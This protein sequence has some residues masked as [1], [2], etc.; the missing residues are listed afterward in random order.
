MNPPPTSTQPSDTQPSGAERRQHPRAQADWPI[1]LMLD[2]GPAEG[3]LRDLSRGGVC[4]FLDRSIPIMT[5][6]RVQLELP[7][8]DGVRHIIADGAVVRSE[9]I[10]ARLDHYEIA[11]FFQNLAEPDR[12]AVN[13]YV[14][15]KH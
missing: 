5:A 12:N 9:K 15:S 8:D 7:V 3:K 10:S 13:A 4:F 1:H 14:A 2:E 11:V 6:L